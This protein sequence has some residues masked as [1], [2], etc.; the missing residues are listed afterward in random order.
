MDNEM[1]LVPC[2]I[3]GDNALSHWIK[4]FR[5]VERG[6]SWRVGGTAVACHQLV[7]GRENP[8]GRP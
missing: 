3:S 2:N 4:C 6:S 8:Y 7:I 5:D 1:R